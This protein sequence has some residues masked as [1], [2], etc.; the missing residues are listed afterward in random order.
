MN[1]E[2]FVV[3]RKRGPA[4]QSGGMREQRF[5]REH[6]D[7]LDG[8]AARGVILLGGPLDEGQEILLVVAAS[9]AATAEALLAPDPWLAANLLKTVSVRRWTVLLEAPF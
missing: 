7:F 6:A 5:W 9:D 4:W 2:L 8:L 1:R 3:T